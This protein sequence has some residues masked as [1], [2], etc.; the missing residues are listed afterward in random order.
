MQ[1]AQRTYLTPEEYLAM[2]REAATKS[3]YLNGEVFAMS[4]ASEAHN[5]IVANLVSLLITALRGDPVKLTPVICVSRL[6]L[7]VCTL[8]LMLP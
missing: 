2:E 4:G 3:E 6:E 1:E 8:I 5:L 7:L